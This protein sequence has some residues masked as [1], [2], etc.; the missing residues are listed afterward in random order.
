MRV[1]AQ[2]SFIGKFCLSLLIIKR[3]GHCYSDSGKKQTIPWL[4]YEGAVP[5][6][7]DHHSER[8]C[9]SHYW[10]ISIRFHFMIIINCINKICKCWPLLNVTPSV[11]T[12]IKPSFLPFVE[13]TVTKAMYTIVSTKGSVCHHILHLISLNDGN[14]QCVKWNTVPQ[15]C[16]STYS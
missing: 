13:F 7:Q 11:F 8:N 10:V 3:G 2:R 15:K 1:N 4:V 9:A 5:I 16:M 6:S 12:W 14:N